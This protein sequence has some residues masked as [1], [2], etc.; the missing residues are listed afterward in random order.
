MSV[1]AHVSPAQGVHAAPGERWLRRW[2]PLAVLSGAGLVVLV[3]IVL[4][5]TGLVI[6]QATCNERPVACGLGQNLAATLFA[7]ALAYFV[8]FGWKF[9]KAIWCYRRKL[10]RNAAAMV[11]DVGANLAANRSVRGAAAR[12]LAKSMAK[13]S[14]AGLLVVSGEEGAGKTTFLAALAQELAHGRWLPV[15][16]SVTHGEAVDFMQRARERFFRTIDSS[17]DSEGSADA[18]WRRVRGTHRLVILVDGIDQCEEFDTGSRTTRERLREAVAEVL[19]ARIAL[20]LITVNDE[21]LADSNRFEPL[22]EHL[23]LLDRSDARRFLRERLGEPGTSGPLADH[24]ETVL[25]VFE[26]PV[27]GLRASPFQ[28]SRLADVEQAGPPNGEWIAAEFRDLPAQRDAARVELL[29]LYIDGLESGAIMPDAFSTRAV[30]AGQNRVRRKEAVQAAVNLA[31]SMFEN[32]QLS[33]PRRD[34]SGA[35][36]N[37]LALELVHERHGRLEFPNDAFHAFFIARSFGDWP[38]A[39]LKA[40][41]ELQTSRSTAL[42]RT[43]RHALAALRMWCVLHRSDTTAKNVCDELL[44]VGKSDPPPRPAIVATAARI[45][46]AVDAEL[47]VE[48]VVE[49]AEKAEG[50]EDER[51]LLV[52]ALALVDRPRAWHLLW[53]FALDRNYALEWPAACALARGG[54]SAFAALARHA[55]RI[56]ADAQAQEDRRELGAPNNS[57]GYA[58]GSL[59]WILP[60]LRDGD[61][62]GEDLYRRT[63]ALCL[64][65]AMTPLRGEL[66]LVH[67]LKLA[68]TDRPEREDIAHTARR[69]LEADPPLRFWHARLDL[70]HVLTIHGWTRTDRAGELHAVLQAARGRER[71]PLVLAA[72]RLGM[73]ALRAAHKHRDDVSAD[74]TLWSY[75]WSSDGDL[76][77]GH[78]AP[79]GE[80]SRLGADAVLLNNLLYGLSADERYERGDE[81]AA[82]DGV[83][84][85]VGR[86]LGRGAANGGCRCGQELCDR[87]EVHPAVAPRAPFSESF[88]RRQA[89]LAA[90]SAAPSWVSIDPFSPGRARRDLV[91]F[92]NEMEA[93]ARAARR[94]GGAGQKAAS[95]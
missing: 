44:Q 37:A 93:K 94:A 57:L 18:I 22:R 8:L 1:P 91:T 70:G 87:V 49:Q 81:L 10:A 59:A 28:L 38:D 86:S 36:D 48:S 23:D 60:S 34:V 88:C 92:W 31:R 72:L 95:V 30:D 4:D 61:G 7:L 25:N 53:R 51:Q 84:D 85:C 67:G 71:H 16:I 56:L 29:R 12:R 89:R 35:I 82:M 2:L 78:P 73:S 83:P 74:H 17:V 69:L 66:S 32:N 6:T 50:R 42:E 21:L 11:G 76:V 26:D 24:L 41:R 46:A 54:D 33:V 68:I 90:E 75:V 43:E 52:R 77:G 58:V 39:A 62:E 79:S 5:A 19:E 9:E 63:E 15:P 64:D 14:G 65:P 47:L 20:V 3:P 40:C 27:D 13:R 80:A 55:E 45:V